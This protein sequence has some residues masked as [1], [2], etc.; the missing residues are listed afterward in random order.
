MDENSTFGIDIAL[1]N[2]LLSDHAVRTH[3]G[4]SAA[5]QINKPHKENRDYSYGNGHSQSSR[6]LNAELGYGSLHQHYR[7]GN[8]RYN[9]AEGKNAVAGH[10]RLQREQAK[11][12]QDQCDSRP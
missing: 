8:H 1:C 12:Q 7:A 9:P 5:R 2:T 6:E 10:R 4:F 3:N 11:R